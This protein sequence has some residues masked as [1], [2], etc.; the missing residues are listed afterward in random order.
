VPR[1]R[2]RHGKRD[3]IDAQLG[4]GNSSSSQGANQGVFAAVR[5]PPAHHPDALDPLELPPM[6]GRLP[7]MTEEE[8]TII[9]MGGAM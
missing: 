3:V 6:Y 8:M 2:F 1:I 5:A 9:D 4:L 7:P